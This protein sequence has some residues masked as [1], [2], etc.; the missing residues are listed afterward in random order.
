MILRYVDLFYNYIIPQKWRLNL[1]IEIVILLHT[2]LSSDI[3]DRVD[4]IAF[5]SLVYRHV[6]K[7]NGV[8]NLFVWDYDF[9]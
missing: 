5:L 9:D 4:T 7:T 1:L 6:S 8:G 2:F 3:C